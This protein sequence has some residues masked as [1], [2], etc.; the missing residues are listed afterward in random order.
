[1]HVQVPDLQVLPHLEAHKGNE[2]GVEGDVE[3]ECSDRDER[4]Q[5]HHVLGLHDSTATSRGRSTKAEV[6]QRA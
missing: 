2:R 3:Q 6:L 4:R 5:Q 1:M